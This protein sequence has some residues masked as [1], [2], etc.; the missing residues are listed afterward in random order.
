MPLAKKTGIVSLILCVVVI[1]ACKTGENLSNTPAANISADSII[2]CIANHEPARDSVSLRFGADFTG[3]ENSGSFNGN[4]RVYRDSLIWISIRKLGVEGARMHLSPDSLSFTDR[5]HKG[6][7]KGTYRFF[8]HKFGIPMD[9]HMIQSLIL[10]EHFS[11]RSDK[12]QSETKRCTDSIFQCFYRIFEKNNLH[13]RTGIYLQKWYQMSSLLPHSFRPVHYEIG[14]IFSGLMMDVNYSDFQSLPKGE[15]P[16]SIQFL[17]SLP[18]KTEL[19]L[20]IAIHNMEYGKSMNTPFKI[21][22][23]YKPIPF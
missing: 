14:E 15:Y 21:P 1:S 20:K 23:S 2:S 17:M 8:I 10:N 4:I 19:S 22:D 6:Y 16:H 11:I 18:D 13:T 9:Y 12:M 5:T 7:Y 3:I